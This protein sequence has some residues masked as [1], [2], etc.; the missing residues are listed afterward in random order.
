MPNTHI[1]DTYRYTHK[2]TCI[3]NYGV[4]NVNSYVQIYQ[5]KTKRNV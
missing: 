5:V 4:V 2:V 3:S 1:L